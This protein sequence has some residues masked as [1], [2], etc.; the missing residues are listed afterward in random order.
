[1][2]PVFP[3]LPDQSVRYWAKCAAERTDGLRADVCR[4]ARFWVCKSCSAALGFYCSLDVLFLFVAAR[5]A[6][7][8]A[9]VTQERH[10]ARLVSLSI[11]H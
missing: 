7:R 11:V 1:M 6:S 10:S 5:S 4:A 9:F 8:A 3:T 2:S